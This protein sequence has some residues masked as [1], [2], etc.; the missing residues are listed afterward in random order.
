[1]NTWSVA[2]IETGADSVA[3][4]LDDAAFDVWTVENDS[5][6]DGSKP[7]DVLIVNVHKNS[8]DDA[9]A[10]LSA[11]HK[12][13]HL[14]DVPMILVALDW[15]ECDYIAALDANCFDVIIDEAEMARL[16]MTIKNAAKFA[17]ERGQSQQRLE[18]AN[19][20]AFTALSDCSDLGEN[21]RCLLEVQE[22]PSLE[23]V[24]EFIFAAMDHYQLS[25][26]LQ[27]RSQFE[28]HTVDE[29]GKASDL[30]A[31]LLMEMH[32]KGRFLPYEKRLV[33]NYD[34]VSLLI[35][36]MPDDEK[37]AGVIRDNIFSIVQGADS[38]VK[39][40]DAQQTLNLEK[41]VMDRLTSRMKVTVS[42]VDEKYQGVMVQCASLVEDMA[43]KIEEAIVHL[44]LT[45]EQEQALQGIARKGVGEINSFF[46]AGLK[47]DEEFKRLIHTM[48]TAVEGANAGHA[49]ESLIRLLKTL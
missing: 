15:T 1:M 41:K 40:L 6:I 25:C 20:M 19:Q 33:L 48:N 17:A 36:N 28:W 5:D 12:T 29:N 24:S 3:P 46:S 42:G 30:E 45:E 18:K 43:A 11:L 21:I 35:R 26:V 16:A 34:T 38:R 22:A 32:D 4:Q 7:C 39:A 47:I 27:L 9:F 13:S 31:K 2:V 8:P 44:G 23:K 10:R 49:A 37:R 14:K